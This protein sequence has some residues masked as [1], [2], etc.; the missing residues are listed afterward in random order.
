MRSIS[1][2]LCCIALCLGTTMTAQVQKPQAKASTSASPSKTIDQLKPILSERNNIPPAIQRFK[3]K[4]SFNY[5]S[6]NG[7]TSRVKNQAQLKVSLAPENDLAIQ[8][9]GNLK[10]PIARQS[11]AERSYDY[12]EAIKSTIQIK[13]PTQEFMLHKKTTDK[14]GQN[15]LRMQQMYL[16]V[17]V[18]GSEVILHEKEGK[19]FLFNGRYFPT[20]RLSTVVPTLQQAS[21][22]DLA[23]QLVSD[24]TSFK[25]LSVQ[26]KQLLPQE[27]IKSQLV[28]YHKDL[29]LDAEKLAWHVSIMPDLVNRWEYF[30]DAHT[31]E[32][33]HHY[34]NICKFFWHKDHQKGKTHSSITIQEDI[35]APLDNLAT[36][37]TLIQ[38]TANATD[39]HNVSQVINTFQQGS[40][41]FL[42]DGSR[43]MYNN[44]SQVPSNPGGMIITLRATP[45]SSYNYITSSTN[46][47]GD[48]TSVSAHYN[49]GLAY[50]YFENTFGRNSINGNGGNII[51]LINVLDENG[52]KMD[53][54]YWN[55]QAMFYGDGKQAFN[56][57]L[58]KASD[59]AG[60][61]MSHGV[62]QAEANLEY[63]GQSGALN[64]S[65]ADVF[66]AMIDRE[67]WKIGEEISNSAVFPSGTMRDMQNPNNGGNSNNFY[68]QPDHMNDFQN[69]PNT[70]QGDNGGVHINSG[71]PNHAF[72]LFATTVGK[73]KAERVYYKALTDYLSKSSQF[74][75]QRNAVIQAAQDLYGTTEVNAAKNA[76]NQVGI[77]EGAGTNPE[78]DVDVNPGDDF[79]LTS[80]SALTQINLYNNQGSFVQTISN[81]THISKPSISDDGSIVVFID[82][83]NEMKEIDITYGASI[84]VNEYVLDNQLEWRNAVVSRDGNRLA[85][86]TTA[87][88]NSIYFYDFG[89]Q[90]WNT[91]NLYNPTTADPSTGGQ[92]TTGDVLYADAMEFDF[93]G[94]YLMYDAF[95]RIENNAGGSNIEYWDIGFLHV[96]NQNNWYSNEGNIS[97]LFSS[98]P[99]NTSVGNPS[100]SKNSPY[101]IGFDW[102]DSGNSIYAANIEQQEI[103]KIYENNT[104]GYPSFSRLDD[105]IIFTTQDNSTEVVI[106]KELAN[107]KITPLNN[108]AFYLVNDIATA[109]GVWYAAGER[110]VGINDPIVNTTHLK[111][112]PNPFSHEFTVEWEANSTET[113][114]IEL[115][116]VL[117]SIVHQQKYSVEKGLNKLSLSFE[118]LTSGAYILKI[119]QANSIFTH[120]ILKR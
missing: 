117:G 33:I 3:A 68:W 118:N 35:L 102:I 78:V 120:K 26:E 11:A 83:N 105:V 23:K 62:I 96:W 44:S 97:K 67:D 111:V 107:D 92:I 16:G 85:G 12:L 55:G 108:S 101:I 28:I 58:A 4:Q 10:N 75:D 106:L 73:T 81:T 43:N 61:E 15:H 6:I 42:F 56:A 79:I 30:I 53:N 59:V 112:S 29:Q 86:I 20:P 65:F 2:L 119:T 1:I 21:A 98:L 7:I 36:E 88:D 100:F 9:K 17:P 114:I 70:P 93:S 77:G 57:P 24:Y 40:N 14:L 90:E 69:L 34:S 95:N 115:V 48:K 74:I 38:T 109:W 76:F 41:Y 104:L 72:Y 60:H 8:I 116:N 27:Q 110:P 84:S 89:I 71:I 113:A 46:S 50:E 99:D 39:L 32:V 5:K 103:S 91:Y 87:L 82:A 45:S 18:Y 49:G 37:E 13:Q 47:W 31:G 54:A 80:N 19:T 66:G 22:E 63:Q 25:N 64:E 94:E 52:Q 51:S